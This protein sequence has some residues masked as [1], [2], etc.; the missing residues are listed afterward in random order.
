MK[1]ST[2]PSDVAALDAALRSVIDYP[3][4]AMDIAQYQ[5]D[6]FRA[7]VARTPDWRTVVSSA[8]VRWNKAWVA[9]PVKAEAA[10]IRWM[11]G[12]GTKALYPCNGALAAN[13]IL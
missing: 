12:N 9:A 13:W 2:R 6:Q 11:A 4:V 8:S 5:V 7:W 10:I 3:A 1:A